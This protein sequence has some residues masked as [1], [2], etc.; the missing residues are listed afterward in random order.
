MLDLDITN[1]ITL[2]DITNNFIFLNILMKA[3]FYVLLSAALGTFCVCDLVSF[4]LNKIIKDLLNL[5]VDYQSIISI[6]NI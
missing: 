5:L 2:K 4:S 6:A 1:Q 3:V